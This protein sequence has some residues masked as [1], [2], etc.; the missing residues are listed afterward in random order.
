MLKKN[1]S[2]WLAKPLFMLAT[3]L[4]VVIL[5]TGQA[6]AQN[7]C[8]SMKDDLLSHSA[9]LPESYE[10]TEILNLRLEGEKMLAEGRIADAVYT[11]KTA[12]ERFPESQLAHAALRLRI[13]AKVPHLTRSG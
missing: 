8:F 6:L 3:M 7:D 1:H 4:L 2:R 5:T 11:F 13:E 10:P 12:T 9:A